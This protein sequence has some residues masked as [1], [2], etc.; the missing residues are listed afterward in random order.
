MSSRIKSIVTVHSNMSTMSLLY[1]VLQELHIF[2]GQTTLYP[3][4]LFS[5][6]KFPLTSGLLKKIS[7][8]NNESKFLHVMF[9]KM[10]FTNEQNFRILKPNYNHQK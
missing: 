10:I 8:M 3:L 6:Q 5:R 2:V 9:I 4:F 7:S 1:K